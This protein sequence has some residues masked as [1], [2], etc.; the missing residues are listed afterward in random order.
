MGIRG[1]ISFGFATTLLMLLVVACTAVVS[2]RSLG[3]S[4][5]DL[6][7]VAFT[8]VAASYN[9]EQQANLAVQAAQSW[10]AS[11]KPD[12]KA[13][14]QKAVAA[15]R[16]NLD[17]MPQG[18]SASGVKE[19]RSLI[20]QFEAIVA[21]GAAAAADSRKQIGILKQKSHAATWLA[22][23]FASTAEQDLPGLMVKTPEEK[24][25]AYVASAN[26]GKVER[27]ILA[28]RVAEQAFMIERQQS[29]L[30]QLKQ[31]FDSLGE[32][33]GEMES[34]SSDDVQIL[35]IKAIRKATGEAIYAD[36]IAL[37][38]MAHGKILRSPHAHARI[39]SIE[40]SAAEKMPG[41]RLVLHAGAIALVVRVAAIA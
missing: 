20:Q 41:V 1:R 21:Q 6:S 40:T 14:F 27:G 37:P 36:D 26:A 30:N 35:K 2:F 39:V 3:N 23:E 17:R 12:S 4:V 22:Q 15:M 29:F 10:I 24:E 34:A 8:R 28:A 13:E 5:A 33:F 38:R 25:K 7:A 19:A 31:Q 18:D 16:S 11:D 9:L 32:L